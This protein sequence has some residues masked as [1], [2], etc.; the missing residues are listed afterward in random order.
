LE[1]LEHVALGPRTTLGVGGLARYL[2]EARGESDVVEALA[3]AERRGVDVRVL[4]GG[5]NLVVSDAGFDGLVLAMVGRGVVLSAPSGDAILTAQAG[6]PWDEVVKIAV[7][8]GLAGLEGL[9][10]I[11]GCAGATPI[12]NVGAYGQEVA[13]TLL[14]VRAV[15]RTTR[16]A[17]ELSAADCRFGYRDSFFKS[18][19]PERYVVS[20]VSFRLSAR[21]PAEARYPEL[22]RELAQRQ[23]SRPTVAELRAAVLSVR[24]RKSMLLDRDDPNGRSC[25]SFFLN[26]IVTTELFE[27]VRRVAAPLEPPSY[28]QAGGHTK[29]AAAWLIE[30]SGFARG[31]RDGNV[32]LST[33]HALSLVAHPGATAADVSRLAGA[34]VRR[35]RERF[36]VELTP[37]PSFWGKSSA[38]TA[39]TPA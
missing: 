28:P 7:E 26:P 20:E 21:P 35:V 5:S 9:S 30:H 17:V 18:Q 29:L 22:E 31:H 6:E 2:V 16:Q 32:G 34:I 3:W 38:Q 8:R 13:E 25:G 4:G 12:Q 10:G 24:S 14:S 11:P 15:D 1:L 33:K 36:G 39:A 27:Q 23:L 19:A 37:E